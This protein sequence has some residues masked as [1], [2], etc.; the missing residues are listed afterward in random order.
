MNNR[1]LKGFLLATLFLIGVLM[2]G[3]AAYADKPTVDFNKKT[4]DFTFATIDTKAT[5]DILW[6]TIGFTVCREPTSGYPRKN[7]DGDSKTQDWAYFDLKQ[8]QKHQYD[9]G[10]GVHVQ[11]TFTFNKDQINAAFKNTKLDEIKDNDK[12][13]FNGVFDII[14]NGTEDRKNIY[15]NLTGKP[16]GIATAETWANPNDFNDHFDLP[17][18]FTYG[19]D[20][21]EPITV[22]RRIYSNGTSTVYDST[23]YPKQT[24][25]TTFSTDWHNVAKK[26][27]TNGKEYYLYRLYYINLRDSKKIIGN[28]KT[29]VSPYL[30]PAEYNTAVS[31]LRDREYTVKDK[32]LKIVALYRRFTEK[33][34]EKEGS[35]SREFETI[36]PTGLIKADSRGNEAYDVL[37]GIPGTESVYANVSV[38]KYL[39]GYIFKKK[40][41]TK[42]YPVTV[43]KTYTLKWTEKGEDGKPDIPHT[44]IRT[45]PKTYYI[46]RKYSYWYIDFLGVYGLEK[47]TVAND[48]LPGGS[49]T[50]TP[51]GYSL[52]AV[53]YT[54]S[55]AEADH[56][57]E[58]KVRI[59]A[60]LSQTISGGNTEPSIPEDDLK[61]YAEMA[62]DKI[63]CRNDKLTFNG[64]TIMSDT[65]KEEKTETPAAIP[66]GTEE[67]GENV[68]YKAGLVIPGNKANGEYESSGS[69]SYKPVVSICNGG[70]EPFETDTNYEID[71]LNPIVVHT[72]VVCDGMVQDNRSDNQ[73]LTPDAGRASLVL[74]RPFN[75]TLPTTGG[76]RFIQGYGYRDYEKYIADRE[77]KFAFDVYK[78]SSAAGT[79]IPKNTWTSVAENTSF[80]LPTWVT[81][82]RYEIRY[83]STAI[84]AAANNG[85]GQTED[86]ANISLSNYVAEDSSIVQ[87]SGRI[88]GLSIYDV[89]DYPIWEKVFRLP[90]SLK[91]TGFRYNVGTRNQNG[92][93]NGQNSKYTLTMVNGSHPHYKNQGIL[94]TGYM[95]RFSL[96]TVGS[97]AD[98][99]DYV[100]IIP[101]FYFVD[102]NG[103]S[104]QEADIYYTESFNGKEHTLVKMGGKVD[105]E[106]SKSIKTGDPYLGIPE[107]ELKRTAYYEGIPLRKWKSQTKKIYNFKNILLPSSLR[108]FI[109]SADTIPQMITE[110][111]IASS[112]Q[113]WYGEYYLPAE[114][115]IVPKGYDITAYALRHGGLDYHES[116]WLKEGYIIVNFDIT[117]VK[118]G[119]P[120]LSYINAVNSEKGYCNMWQREGYQYRK[121]NYD[122]INFQFQDGDYVIYYAN[123]SVK[124]DYLSAGTH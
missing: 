102:K 17:A 57:I 14:Y 94:K 124:E 24:K 18:L 87:I 39:S 119:E 52:P 82:G 58:P 121:T 27:D 60:P 71:D 3:R 22:E 108:T 5:T 67:I 2:P 120:N 100:Q 53:T 23:D 107:N 35:I 59:T 46:E 54:N 45:V 90:N 10:D 84:N 110:K 42:L 99:D 88:Y 30:S 72:P 123:R 78:G 40:E 6:N 43:T 15:Y 34:T 75:V 44:D 93:S 73:M 31:Y 122:G 9:V 29:S 41:G 70:F 77:V 68:F 13:Y 49:I 111:Q 65:K 118:D 79:F 21:K 115:H 106:N 101:K 80:Y 114:V 11:V 48:A 47:A 66:E 56:I 1:I 104:R 91:L 19:T 97:M 33:E 28:R 61:S 113:N 69:V 85:N 51:S 95:T 117:T 26:V 81:E 12:I 7:T 96:T 16:Y 74:D 25:N 105:L 86:L 32:G 89:T 50:L 38:N 64:Q 4:G 92:E 36:D 20:N 83:R 62:V 109:G 55:T 116:F 112:V 98:S 63:W 8:G 76:H 37:E 103:K